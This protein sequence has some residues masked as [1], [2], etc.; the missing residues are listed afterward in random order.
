[1][2]GPYRFN[3]YLA[4][5]LPVVKTGDPRLYRVPLAGLTLRPVGPDTYRQDNGNGLAANL[6]ALPGGMIEGYTT[7][8]QKLPLPELL[9][10]ALLIINLLFCLLR[11]L[12]KGARLLFL[13]LRRRDRLACERRRALALLP[14]A[15]IAA[16]LLFLMA[17]EEPLPAAGRAAVSALSVLLAVGAAAACLP[18]LRRKDPRPDWLTTVNSGLAVA[19]VIFFELYLF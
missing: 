2:R 15:L 13:A 8:Y 17:A 7:D 3:K 16:L 4:G 10:A 6:H 9:A 5:L 12:F 11:L 14:A 19:A 1:M 18:I